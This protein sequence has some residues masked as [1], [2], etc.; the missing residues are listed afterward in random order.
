MLRDCR[1]QAIQAELHQAV[2]LRALFIP[3]HT[4][5]LVNGKR[6]ATPTQQPASSQV[7]PS[8]LPRL[9]MTS[10]GTEIL[11]AALSAP[12]DDPLGIAAHPLTHYGVLLTKLDQFERINLTTAMS[13]LPAA[14]QK[15]PVD[16]AELTG[17]MDCEYFLNF[18]DRGEGSGGPSHS[19]S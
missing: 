19:S 12:K 3:G 14:L 11:Q 1:Q 10:N 4:I 8:W 13:A 18:E 5:Q 6:Q 15:E 7:R 16:L 2:Q 17:D 9:D